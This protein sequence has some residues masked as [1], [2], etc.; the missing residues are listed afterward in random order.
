MRIARVPCDSR[1]FHRFLPKRRFFENSRLATSR[2]IFDPRLRKIKRA[3]DE[4]GSATRAITQEHADLTVLDPP[5]RAAVLSRDARRFRSL[6]E[7]TG[8]V[9]DEH[10]VGLAELLH[11]VVSQVVSHRIGRFAPHRGPNEH[12]PRASETHAAWRLSPGAD[13]VTY[14]VDFSDLDAALAEAERRNRDESNEVRLE[15]R[16]R[17]LAYLNGGATAALDDLLRDVSDGLV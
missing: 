17:V 3:I 2:R 11:G 4:C 1:V 14:A 5:R 8:L 13:Y 15:R 6:F 16:A 12:V 7:E 9:D 10:A